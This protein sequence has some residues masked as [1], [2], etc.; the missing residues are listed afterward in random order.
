MLNRTGTLDEVLTGTADGLMERI[1]GVLAAIT[2]SVGVVL[3]PPGPGLLTE[4]C[5]EP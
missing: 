5:P 4:I 1:V 2:S 3:L